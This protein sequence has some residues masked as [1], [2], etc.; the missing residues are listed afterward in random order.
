MRRIVLGTWALAALA[1]CDDPTHPAEQSV[2]PSVTVVQ[3]QFTVQD[4]G[5]LGGDFGGALGINSRGVVVGQSTIPSGDIHAF[6]WRAGRGMRDLGT[7]GGGSS[8]ARGI[9]DH[10]QVAGESDPPSAACEHSSGPRQV[11]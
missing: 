2:T 6:L 3:P 8:I 10:G 1:A 7:L 4:L 9:N 5:T 11:G